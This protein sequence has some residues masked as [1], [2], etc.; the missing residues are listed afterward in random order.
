MVIEGRLALYEQRIAHAHGRFHEGVARYREVAVQERALRGGEG[1]VDDEVRCHGGYAVNV[2]VVGDVQVVRQ[3]C[4]PLHVQVVRDVH[5]VR[6]V[7][8]DEGVYVVFVNHHLRRPLRIRSV[9]YNGVLFVKYAVYSD[10]G[11]HVSV[12]QGPAADGS[13]L[14]GVC[15]RNVHIPFESIVQHVEID[16]SYIVVLVRRGVS[17]GHAKMRAVDVHV[18]GV[19]VRVEGGVP[20]YGERFCWIFDVHPYFT[21]VLYSEDGVA[22]FVHEVCYAIIAGLHHC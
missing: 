9:E 7:G 16:A 10:E 2:Y 14:A 1:T 12:V 3:R 11:V 13:P 8:C 4:H 18:T 21:V 22:V 19:H 17:I 15:F 20:V 6:E 5:V